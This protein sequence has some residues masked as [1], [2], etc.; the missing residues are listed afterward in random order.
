M[1]QLVITIIAAAVLCVTVSAQTAS[2]PDVSV[3]QQVV[4]EIAQVKGGTTPAEWLKAHPD[5]KLQMFNGRQLANDTNEWCVRTVVAHAA[6][7]DRAWTRSVYFYDPKAPDDDALPASGTSGRQILEASCQ[8]GLMWVDIPENDPAVGTK[9]AEEIQAALAS[10]YGPG[11]T[12][13]FGADGFGAIG[14]TD[15]REWQVD[16]AVL[17]VAY[18]QFR[19]KGHRVLVR[20]AFANS[21][22]LHD[23]VKAT[24]RTRIDLAAR[25]DALIRKLKEAGLP[26]GATTAMIELLE[27]PDYFSGQ[28]LPSDS[29]VVATFRVWLTAAKSQ[30]A[31]QQ[32]VA[33]LAADRVL[34]FLGHNGVVLGDAARAEMKSLGAEYVHD[35]L[36]GADV[37]AHGLLARAKALAPP[38]PASDEMLLLQM[39]HGFDETGMCSAGEE[40]FT[41]VIEKGESLLAGA[42]TLNTSTLSSLHFMVGDAYATIVWLATTSD[43]EYHDP[44]KYQPEAKSARAKAL[45]HYRAAF[46]LEQGT[47]RAQKAWKEAWRLAEGLPPLRGRYF[48]IYD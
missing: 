29:Q 15:T 18:D 43:T 34:G 25:S 9:L 30:P 33:L 31:E 37:Y 14:W 41:Q 23:I 16:G 12:P 3:A 36:A 17:T 42:R 24:E 48:C 39:E 45:E 4:R 5:E 44:K 47:A 28:N 32:A 13:K 26:A 40:E 6:T 7:T 1:R 22:A 27:K 35:E 2:S 8:L 21:D 19:G 20:L 10:Q 11:A 38:G 46:K